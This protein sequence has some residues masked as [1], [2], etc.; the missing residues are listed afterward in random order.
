MLVAR[1]FRNEGIMR[2]IRAPGE[3]TSGEVRANVG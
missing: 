2:T 1:I 3:R